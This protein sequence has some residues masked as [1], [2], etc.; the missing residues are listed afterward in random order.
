MYYN[1]IDAEEAQKSEEI[2]VAHHRS[3]YEAR[4]I[5]T[6]VAKLIVAEKKESNIKA[7]MKI[8]EGT[9]ALQRQEIEQRYHIETR[10]MAT[11]M[12]EMSKSVDL[13]ALREVSRLKTC[14]CMKIP[15]KK[16]RVDA[17]KCSSCKVKVQDAYRSLLL[18]DID[19]PVRAYILRLVDKV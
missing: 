17:C 3:E 1:N 7:R 11:E 5:R 2:L 8:L 15:H 18:T 19:A 4:Q 10:L 12:R 14:I 16:C 13:D 9:E 6:A